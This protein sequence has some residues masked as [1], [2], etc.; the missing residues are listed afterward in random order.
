MLILPDQ[1]EAD[2]V[3]KSAPPIVDSATAGSR[4]VDIVRRVLRTVSQPAILGEREFAVSCS[5]GLS[6][7]P[8][9]GQDAET[10]LRN[11]DAAMYRAKDLGRNMFQFYTAELHARI[12]ERVTLQGMLRRAVEREEFLLHYQPKVHLKTGRISGVEAL[13]R[14]NSPE[15]GLIQPYRFI[16]MLEDTGMIVDVGRWVMAKAVADYKQWVA[17]GRDAPRIAV[18]VS[19]VQLAQAG[20]VAIVNDV[21]SAGGDRAAG[22]DLEITE[23][24]IMRDIEANISKLKTIREM[25]VSIAID[26]FGTGYSSLSY[27]AK[28]PVDTLKIDRAFI[29]NVTTGSDDLSI[30]S[31]IISLASSLNLKVVA[32]GV[33]TEEQAK[34]L[35]LFDCDE[36]QGYLISRPVPA[37]EL[38]EWHDRYLQGGQWPAGKRHPEA[39]WRHL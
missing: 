14:W 26:D 35:R 10:L 28:L 37:K 7:F 36:I 16:P 4:I 32:E 8:Q 33:E 21:L 25:G 11:A 2:D 34:V 30:V 20:F 39:V 19:Q 23:S 24:L 29:N 31:T 15:Q 6:M 13:L 22:L 17:E 27:L 18:N 1:T 12:N 3:S 38:W 9:D 5:I